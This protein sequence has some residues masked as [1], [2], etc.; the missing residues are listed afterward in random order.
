MT[1]SV[2][3][4]RSGLIAYGA[5]FLAFEGLFI[6]FFVLGVLGRARGG[7]GRLWGVPESSLRGPWGDLGG[8]LGRPCAKT[9]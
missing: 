9:L 8:T 2:P 7:L 3:I 5:S 6:V 1:L 4:A